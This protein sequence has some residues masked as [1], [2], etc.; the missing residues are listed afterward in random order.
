VLVTQSWESKA[1]F[2]QY[3]A[4]RETAGSTREFEAR[5]E[6]ETVVSF[7]ESI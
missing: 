2:E 6:G 5:A 3:L 7:Y 1:D 4:W